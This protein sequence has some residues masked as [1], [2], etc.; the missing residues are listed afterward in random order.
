MPY[1]IHR[2]TVPVPV[3]WE[4]GGIGW[5]GAS[6]GPGTIALAAGGIPVA[7]S[8]TTSGFATDEPLDIPV[9]VKP[10]DSDPS[11]MLV[12]VRVPA[13]GIIGLDQ[14]WVSYWEDE[15]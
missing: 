8:A 14:V 7:R 9:Y 6:A 15:A 12:G 4:E 11:Y 13:G 2:K 5:A 3:Y 10:S 1:G